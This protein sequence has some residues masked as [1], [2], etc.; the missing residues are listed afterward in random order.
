MKSDKQ[1]AKQALKPY[2]ALTPT[3]R[4]SIELSVARVIRHVRREM[5]REAAE[6]IEKLE[7]ARKALK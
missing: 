2:V 3:I 7:A 6:A 5:D 4:D 1:W